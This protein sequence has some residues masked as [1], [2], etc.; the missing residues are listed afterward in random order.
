MGRTSHVHCVA[1]RA[2]LGI[3]VVSQ[4]LGSCCACATGGVSNGYPLVSRLICIIPCLA[5]AWNTQNI[6]GVS[7]PFFT[8]SSSN[9]GHNAFAC[10]PHKKTARGRGLHSRCRSK[11]W[12]KNKC[13]FPPKCHTNCCRDTCQHSRDT[14]PV[15]QASC[16]VGLRRE[17][18]IT[19][20]AIVQASTVGWL[21]KRVA[22]AKKS[23]TRR[24]ASG[25]DSASVGSVVS[26]DNSACTSSTVKMSKA[27]TPNKSQ[28]DAAFAPQSSK[29]S[30]A[31]LQCE[32]AKAPLS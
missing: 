5:H 29:K 2:R 1:N 27:P 7:L 28:P 24:T 32:Q 13:I 11:K 3:R 9:G 14:S 26:G 25:S 16:C 31:T 15:G 22:A 30:V 12:N 19:H 6:R 18:K 23:G 8:S 21:G 17:L 10:T 20:V 4:R